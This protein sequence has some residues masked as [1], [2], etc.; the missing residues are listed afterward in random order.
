MLKEAASILKG[1]FNTITNNIGLKLLAVVFAVALWFVVV[2]TDDPKITKRYTSSI[3]LENSDYLTDQGKYFELLDGGNTIS[4]DVTA[5][6][7]Y[8]DQL[9]STDFRVVADLKNTEIEADSDVATV[10][11]EILPQ[12]YASQVTVSG[13]SKKIQLLIDDL[14]RGQFIVSPQITGSLSE[15]RELGS[16]TA[17]PNLVTVYGP[18]TVI[19]EIDHIGA[20]VDVTDLI[21]DVTV[22]CIPI[23]YDADGNVIETGRAEY[24]VSTV[25]VSVSVLD[26]KTV[27]V[28]CSYSGEPADGYSLKEIKFSPSSV[29]VKGRA[30][31][32]NSITSVNIPAQALD[33]TSAR[34]DV[35]QVVD[36][37][38]YL[39]TGVTVVGDGKITVTAVID[40]EI[41]KS[42]TLFTSN[43]AVLNVPEDYRAVFRD[44]LV[45]VVL[46]GPE[47]E[48]NK[49][50]SQSLAGTVDATGFQP[51]ENR[52]KILLDLASGVTCD[53][54]FASVSLIK[55]NVDET[56]ATGDEENA[57]GADP[58]GDEGELTEE[59][60]TGE[61]VSETGETDTGLAETD[62]QQ[63][64]TDLT[65]D[66]TTENGASD[67][68]TVTEGEVSDTGT[69]EV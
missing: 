11:I 60:D 54:I 36:A 52:A 8:M 10:P 46:T 69:P 42:F 50:N 31:A 30:Q 3:T 40:E 66:T 21:S 15:G 58:S 33:I 13:Y 39:P 27:G 59:N 38:E 35:T 57:D 9:S 53:E 26:T 63:E 49:I 5:K 55:E 6:R 20:V 48:I 22:A 7:S 12:R 29:N 24:N 2:N 32:L 1:L 44:S 61:T 18:E 19:G 28:V 17:T 16:V 14:L 56:E 43:I 67:V 62:T 34:G 45:Q 41:S 51:G 4:F 37:S 68:E 23:A 47:D 65:T 25:T 64:T